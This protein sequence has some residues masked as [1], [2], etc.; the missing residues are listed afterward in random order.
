MTASVEVFEMCYKK[1]S[2]HF[3]KLAHNGG[4][5]QK[6]LYLKLVVSGSYVHLTEAFVSIIW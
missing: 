6:P 1:M 4:A 3:S 5:M 2:A